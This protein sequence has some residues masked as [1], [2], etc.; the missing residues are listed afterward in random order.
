VIRNYRPEDTE[1]GGHAALFVWLNARYSPQR[2]D[3]ALAADRRK[4]A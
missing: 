3:A 1:A 2:P 4:V